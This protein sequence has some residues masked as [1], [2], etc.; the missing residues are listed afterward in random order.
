MYV[1][2]YVCMFALYITFVSLDSKATSFLL[3]IQ[4]AS[5]QSSSDNKATCDNKQL[6]SERLQVSGLKLR[7]TTPPDGNCLFHA[8]SDQLQR[9]GAKQKY[10][11]RELR[12]L[13]VKHL[14]NCPF[15]VNHFHQYW[16]VDNLNLFAQDSHGQPLDM[17][18]FVTGGDWCQYLATLKK[19]G[20]WGDHITLQY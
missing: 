9:V 12:A 2:M 8:V 4:I 18:H 10:N 17:S 5:T 6:L 13:T 3:N 1:C 7:G 15:T 16:K 20:S 19:D 14:T 11:Y